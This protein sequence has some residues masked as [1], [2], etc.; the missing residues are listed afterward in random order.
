MIGM[1]YL[2]RSDN[3]GSDAVVDVTCKKTRGPELPG[4]SQW[5][6]L[7]RERSRQAGTHRTA[8]RNAGSRFAFEHVLPDRG[9][10]AS[11]SAVPLATRIWDGG[12]P[13]VRRSGVIRTDFACQCSRSLLPTSFDPRSSLDIDQ[14]FAKE[15]PFV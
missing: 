13:H 10:E 15:L 2:N 4:P 14:Q 3:T 5:R 9:E 1:Q 11:E 12:F 6:D 7:M 8:D